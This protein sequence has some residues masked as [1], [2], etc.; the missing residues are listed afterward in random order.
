MTMVFRRNRDGWRILHSTQTR[1]LRLGRYGDWRRGRSTHGCAKS[2]PPCPVQTDHS[3]QLRVVRVDA[4]ID[5]L[6]PSERRRA[7]G[8]RTMTLTSFGSLL[9]AH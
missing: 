4:P 6:L 8:L 9:L 1:R 2:T 3:D 5:A 7:N